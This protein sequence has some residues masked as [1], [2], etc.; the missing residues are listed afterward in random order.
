MPVSSQADF[1]FIDPWVWTASSA[2]AFVCFIVIPDRL[3]DLNTAY[4]SMTAMTVDAQYTIWWVQVGEWIYLTVEWFVELFTGSLANVQI[5]SVLTLII[6]LV[7][8]LYAIWVVHA[9]NELHLRRKHDH[10]KTDEYR[11]KIPLIP[12]WGL[13]ALWMSCFC[14]LFHWVGGLTILMGQV[15]PVLICIG[16][17]LMIFV[18]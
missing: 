13:M 4:A 7:S 3:K 2:C 18:P 11:R 9:K 15:Y 17:M 10:K 14:F 6:Q 8:L 12:S 16:I 5:V 1:D